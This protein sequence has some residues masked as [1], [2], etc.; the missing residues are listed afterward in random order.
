VG[1]GAATARGR[2]TKSL[3]HIENEKCTHASWITNF[4]LSPTNFEHMH[5]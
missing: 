5:V 1:G 3:N 4:P 2:A